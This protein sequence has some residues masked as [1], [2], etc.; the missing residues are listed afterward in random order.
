MLW[1]EPVKTVSCAVPLG[2]ASLENVVEPPNA[3]SRL[4]PEVT[5]ENVDALTPLPPVSWP[6]ETPQEPFEVFIVNELV[7]PEKVYVASVCTDHVPPVRR[8]PVVLAS[9]VPLEGSEPEPPVGVLPP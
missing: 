9:I 1:L 3:S 4:L 8:P 5:A 2:V 7:V 6:L